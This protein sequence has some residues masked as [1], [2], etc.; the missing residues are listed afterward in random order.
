VFQYGVLID[1]L[2]LPYI[3]HKGKQQMPYHA[4]AMAK[5]L[6]SILF[7]NNVLIQPTGMYRLRPPSFSSMIKTSRTINDQKFKAIFS[8]QYI[9]FF[10]I[11]FLIY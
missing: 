11:L 4:R 3:H 8:D 7:F 2:A 9:L 10:S 5:N 6:F 1:Y